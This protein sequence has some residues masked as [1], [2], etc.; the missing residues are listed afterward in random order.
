MKASRFTDSQI[1]AVLTQAEAG[2]PRAT[3]P[4]LRALPHA[5]HWLGHVPKMANQVRRDGGAGE[6]ATRGESESEEDVS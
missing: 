6:G 3:A 1:I 4:G 2:S 5:R